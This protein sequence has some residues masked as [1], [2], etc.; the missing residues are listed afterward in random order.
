MTNYTFDSTIPFAQNNPSVDQ[1]KMLANNV[2]T[3]GIFTQDHIG[4]N[5]N[6]GGTHLQNSYT[7]FSPGTLITGSSAN[8]P[9][10]T[11]PAAGV[12]DNTRAQYYFKNSNNTYPMS[13]MRAWAFCSGAV[14]NPGNSV[15]NSQSVNIVSVIKDVT[16]NGT[17][18][19]TMVANAVASADYGVLVSCSTPNNTTTSVFSISYIITSATTFTLKFNNPSG[20]LFL[21]TPPTNFTFQVLQI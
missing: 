9:S 8:E 17:F 3:A 14:A 7:N 12:A 19:V 11:Y 21:S 18:L 5:A 15:I 6:N 1:P 4:F 10:V 16:L 2:S 20:P 13:C